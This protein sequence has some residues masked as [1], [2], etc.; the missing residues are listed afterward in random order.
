MRRI[1]INLSIADAWGIEFSTVKDIGDNLKMSAG[2]NLYKYHSNG[3]YNGNIYR[4]STGHLTGLFRVEWIA[5]GELKIQASARYLG[6]S[7][8]I[9]GNRLA[10]WYL[11]LAIAKDIFKGNG[12]LSLNS[13][14]LFNT[15]IEQFT[16]SE[17]EYYSMQRYWEPAGIRLNFIYR[18]NERKEDE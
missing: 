15:R 16:I 18:I 5:P 11:N 17:Q 8:T 7:K 2:A 4:T 10:Y 12:T 3:I 6:P 13:E 14:D 1:P 9:Q